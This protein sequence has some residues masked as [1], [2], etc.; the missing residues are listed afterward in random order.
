MNGWI[1]NSAVKAEAGTAAKVVA[2]IPSGSPAEFNADFDAVNGLCFALQCISEITTRSRATGA[3][4]AVN[5]PGQIHGRWPRA[6]KALCS[7]GQPGVLFVR[8]L[9]RVVSCRLSQCVGSCNTDSRCAANNHVANR[10]EASIERLDALPALHI[11]QR[12]LIEQ[13][14][15]AVAPANGFRYI[16]GCAVHRGL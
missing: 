11:G 1:A 4:K 3:L 9:L 6:A 2:A 10:V 14:Q 13:A 7:I 15:L 5:G 8:G 16:G 12:A